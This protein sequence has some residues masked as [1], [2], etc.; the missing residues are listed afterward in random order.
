MAIVTLAVGVGSAGS[1]T[2]ETV[3]AV[4]PVEGSGSQT[5]VPFEYVEVISLIGRARL[6]RFKRRR[7]MNRCLGDL[8]YESKECRCRPSRR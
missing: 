2:D 1:V 8:Q 4:Q 6:C 7:E 3:P 5:R